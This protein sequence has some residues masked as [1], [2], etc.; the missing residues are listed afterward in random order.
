MPLD[1]TKV[2]SKTLYKLP[3]TLYGLAVDPTRPYLYAGSDDNSVVV[4]DLAAE[5]KEPIARWKQ[6]DNYVSAVVCVSRDAKP[7]IVSGSYDRKLIW[8]NEAGEALRT[9]EAHEGWIRDLIALPDGNRLVSAGDDM[10]LKIWETDSGKLVQ[11][12]EGHAKRTPQGHVTALY[13][14]AV[15]P[16]GK[17]L[18]SGDRHGEVRVWETETGKLAQ[19]FEVPV[20]YTYDPVQRKRS[21]GGIRS[22][23][24][25]PD[26]NSLAAGGIGLVNNVD[27]LEGPATVEVWDWRK[28]ERR[29]AAKAQGHKALINDLRFIADGAWLIGGG[30]GSDAG[31]LA[32][33]KTDNPADPPKDAVQR[34]KTDGHLHRIALSSDGATLYVAG[35]RKLEAWSLDG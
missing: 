27:G 19:K 33:W 9:V 30:G 20:L 1:P 24:F 22:L 12:L 11:T 28:P 31:V 16:D 5:K 7:V 17:F 8:W 4:F 32:L 6:H 2:K 3:D 13:V 10:L 21:I 14:V 26:G 15:S 23:V 25:S 29:W 35:Y 34:I 18:A